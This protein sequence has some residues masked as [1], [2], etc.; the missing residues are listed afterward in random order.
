MKTKALQLLD[1][2]L[3]RPGDG[4]TFQA[5]TPGTWR[6][7]VLEILAPQ[8]SKGFFAFINLIEHQ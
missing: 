8:M 6:V 1:K 7:F 5:K 2:M 4:G 3:Q